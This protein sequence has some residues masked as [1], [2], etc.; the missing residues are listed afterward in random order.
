[1]NQYQNYIPKSDAVKVEVAITRP[2]GTVIRLVCDAF[3]YIEI[4]KMNEPEFFPPEPLYARAPETARLVFTIERP[5][6]WTIYSPHI[7]P[8]SIDDGNVVE[9]GE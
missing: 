8:P 5:R 7:E 9:E 4:E 2:D 6:T 1:M 3:D